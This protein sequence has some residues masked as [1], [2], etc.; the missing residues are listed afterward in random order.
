MATP[1]SISRRAYRVPYPF[2]PSDAS[3][4]PPLSALAAPAAARRARGRGLC[5]LFAPTSPALAAL[6]C[7]VVAIA[8]PAAGSASNF[9]SHRAGTLVQE[10]WHHC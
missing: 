7:P 1:A 10:A 6:Q 9:A 8:L 5:S 3:C 4:V 2:G